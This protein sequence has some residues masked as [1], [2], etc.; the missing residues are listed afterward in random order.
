MHLHPKRRAP[1]YPNRVPSSQDPAP[2]WYDAAGVGGARRRIGLWGLVA[3]AA[4]GC[5][6]DDPRAL[7]WRVEFEDF[8]IVDRAR[9]FESRILEGGCDG[10][11]VYSGVVSVAGPGSAPEPPDLEP[12]TWGF[13]VTALDFDCVRYAEGCTEIDLPRQDGA[14]VVVTLAARTEERAC[15]STRCTAGVCTR[16]DGGVVECPDGFA[17]CNG[18]PADECET[19]LETADD[20]G[21]CG[22]DCR[23]P[24]ATP[25]CQSG[26]CAVDE[27]DA[28][29]ADCDGVDENGCETSLRTATDCGA[30]GTICQL[31][32]AAESCAEG[33][34]EL[35]LCHPGWADCDGVLSNGCEAD[36]SA[37]ATCGTCDTACGGTTPLCAVESGSDP[38]CVDVCPAG[39]TMCE[40]SCVQTGGDARHCGG[41]G[42]VCEML[43]GIGRCEAGSCILSAC[44]PLYGDC[45]DLD[46][47]G[48]ETELF[49]ASDCGACGTPCSF[50]EAVTSCVTGECTIDACYG[51]LA[52]CDGMSSTGCEADL[53]STLT[54]GSCETSCDD[55][56]PVCGVDP[57]GEPACL[58]ECAEPRA[59]RCGDRCLDT[60]FDVSSCGGCGATCAVPNGTPRCLEGECLVATCDANRGDCDGAGSNGCEVD[61]LSD[62]DHC[63]ACGTV[64]RGA[65]GVEP[66]CVGGECQTS[67]TPGLGDCNADPSD[68]CETPLDT[69]E[70]CGGCGIG[71]APPRGVGTCERGSCEIVSCDT[72]F[73]DC[74]GSVANGCETDLRS[75]TGSCGACGNRCTP[76]R[77]CDGAC[78]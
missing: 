9:A 17:D 2:P 19:S 11:E 28:D 41:C 56:A 50:P 18:N 38:A 39:T 73:D 77:C 48:C 60:R 76:P 29:W 52:D 10:V 43:H 63:G 44:E 58:A 36:L 67:C 61:L 46:A 7:R 74:D 31:P 14:E 12:G 37:A 6:S 35:V 25:L 66:T 20:C 71:C 21:A 72:G 45:D 24:H 55:A 26:A 5:G 51:G 16:S 49:T 57:A 53:G 68:G 3:V 42:T 70:S 4:A 23:V 15:S 62:P 30:C 69:L 64:C 22:A 75:D 65:G 40:T 47:N 27:C 8:S 33:R 13:S 78:C 34:C 1:C 59:T 54:C 32:H